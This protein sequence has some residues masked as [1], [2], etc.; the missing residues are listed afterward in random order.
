M[1]IRSGT[2]CLVVSFCLACVIAL[3]PINARAQ[4]SA[5]TQELIAKNLVGI[6]GGRHL[7]MVCMG[8]G[9]PTLVFDTGLGG[10]ILNWQ[11]VQVPA[12][13]ITRACFYD[14]AGYGYSD[15]SPDPMTADNITNDLHALLQNAGVSGPVVLVGVSIAGIYATLYT[16]KF[17][18]QVAGLVLI[19]PTSA[20]YGKGWY[21]AKQ[22]SLAEVNDEQGR[23]HQRACADMA[24]AG[25]LTAADPHDCFSFA[26]GRTPAEIAYLTDVY[27][28]PFWYEALVNEI[29]STES[30]TDQSDE[31]SLEE[32]RV[33]ASFGD[34]PVIVLT[35]SNFPPEPN[36]TP[37]DM[38]KRQDG[39]KAGHDRLA[40]RSTRGESIVVPDS[41]HFIMV[42]QPDAVVDAIRKVVME[43]RQ[44]GVK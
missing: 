10:N 29:R 18:S 17:S 21:S 33:A 1:L 8:S 38:K 11:K 28:K 23:A 24:R 32:K 2:T 22:L 43:V 12:S 34:K 36:A 14:R 41:G 42:D 9:S 3:A 25:K 26:K 7:N 13:Q 40:A 15:P 5:G 6:G 35:R 44:S 4:M 30:F 20:D 39:W 19:E 16:D 37:A 31:D 27:T